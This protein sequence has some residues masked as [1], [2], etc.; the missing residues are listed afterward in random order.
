MLTGLTADYC[1]FRTGYIGFGESNESK[2]GDVGVFHVGI[3]HDA[4]KNFIAMPVGG[5][6]NAESLVKAFAE[7]HLFTRTT[8]GDRAKFPEVL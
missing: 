4:R 1:F 6:Q 8:F 5:Q 3:V 2:W 7:E